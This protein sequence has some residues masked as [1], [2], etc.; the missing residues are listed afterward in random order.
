MNAMHKKYPALYDKTE[1][2]ILRKENTLSHRAAGTQL[3]ID[4][5]GLEIVVHPPTHRNSSH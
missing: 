2:V 3:E 5:L 4:V 1:N